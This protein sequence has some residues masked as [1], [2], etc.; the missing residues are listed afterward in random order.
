PDSRV[1]VRG[2]DA[3]KGLTYEEELESTPEL[4]TPIG[5]AITANESP[6]EYMNI[7]V[8]KQ[9]VRLFDIKQL[10]VGDSLLSSGIDMTKLYGRPGMA[11]MITVNNKVISIPGEHGTAPEIIKNNQKAKLDDPISNGDVIH[12]KDG[13]DGQNA[14]AIILDLFTDIPSKSVN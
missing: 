8:N 7:T 4:V 2:I 5:I 11:L 9:N 12:I 3:L 1:A 10:T 13:E 14:Q 6:V